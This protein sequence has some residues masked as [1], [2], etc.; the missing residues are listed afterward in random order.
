MYD[1]VLSFIVRGM[2]SDWINSDCVDC[3]VLSCGAMYMF[4]WCCSVLYFSVLD[5][6]VLCCT[7]LLCAVWNC[8]VLRGFV[9][10]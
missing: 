10:W 7:G 8:I 2:V 4:T 9:L 1:R 6:I 5:C 3:I